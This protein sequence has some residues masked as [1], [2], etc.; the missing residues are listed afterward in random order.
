VRHLIE[1][2]LITH[3]MGTSTQKVFE[4]PETLHVH[5]KMHLAGFASGRYDLQLA[6]VCL[7]EI[8]G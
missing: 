2:A 1:K 5:I 6:D 3:E 4:V 7:L 8:L